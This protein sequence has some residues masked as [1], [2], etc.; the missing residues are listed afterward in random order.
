MPACEFSCSFRICVF[1]LVLGLVTSFPVRLIVSCCCNL[2]P[3]F[4]YAPK[5]FVSPFWF[6][7]RSGAAHSL[8]CVLLSLVVG[9]GFSCSILE[10]A[11][12]VLFL[13]AATVSKP[14]TRSAVSLDFGSHGVCV[15]VNAKGLDFLPPTFP[16]VH[17]VRS[18]FRAMN[19]SSS[20]CS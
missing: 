19:A 15:P 16:V 10:R 20:L 4:I 14:S 6:S 11:R 2:P 9:A 1:Y 7:V 5:I 12:L 8:I 17:F 13:L 18:S 3:D